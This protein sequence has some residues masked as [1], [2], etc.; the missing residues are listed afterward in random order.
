LIDEAAGSADAKENAVG[1]ATFV[2]TADAIRVVR[3]DAL[4]IIHAL[5]SA[6]AADVDAADEERAVDGRVGIGGGIGVLDAQS[7]ADRVA[8]K[9]LDLIDPEIL[10]KF[11]R[12][13]GHGRRR[14]AETGIEATARE[15][16]FGAVAFVGGGVDGE[17]AEFNDLGLDRGRGRTSGRHGLTEERSDGGKRQQKTKP[18]R[19]RRRASERGFHGWGKGCGV[20]VA[21][22]QKAPGFA[23]A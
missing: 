2:V 6:N 14:V 17:R 1:T 20:R 5:R 3:R 7:G 22:P 23:R 13:N 12:E 15:R 11:L 21:W 9:I 10:Q 4:E 18:N 16:V 8:D 19:D